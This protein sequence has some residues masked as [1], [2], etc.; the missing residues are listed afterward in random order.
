MCAPRNMDR[1]MSDDAARI[2]TTPE[3]RPRSRSPQRTP[4]RRPPSLEEAIETDHEMRIFLAALR[5]VLF[6]TTLRGEL[7][8]LENLHALLLLFLSTPRR[9]PP[10]LEAEYLELVED[11]RIMRACHP[12]GQA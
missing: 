8:K 3:G 12:D 2:A 9:R 4:G 5:K 7:S 1:A 10:E 6:A 11:L